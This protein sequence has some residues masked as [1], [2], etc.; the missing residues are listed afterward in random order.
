MQTLG[1]TL[2]V[3][4]G[5]ESFFDFLAIAFR[6]HI[7]DTP[8]FL[9]LAGVQLDNEKRDWIKTRL[10]E[11][12]YFLL[13]RLSLGVMPDKCLDSINIFLSHGA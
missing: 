12:V 6:D 8:A 3:R 5:E 11:Q 9:D 1:R 10:K 7:A 2:L 4:V 13:N